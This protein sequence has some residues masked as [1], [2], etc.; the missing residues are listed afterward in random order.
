MFSGDEDYGFLTEGIGD[1][2]GDDD[3]DFIEYMNEEDDYQQ[4]MGSDDDYS[5]LDNDECREIIEDAGFDLDDCD[6]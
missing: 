3:I 1:L 2:D 5:V 4:I 6:F